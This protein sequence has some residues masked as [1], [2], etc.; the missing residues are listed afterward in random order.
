[1]NP[2]ELTM[3]VFTK[4]TTLAVATAFPVVTDALP[5]LPPARLFPVLALV[6]TSTEVVAVLLAEMDVA[7]DELAVL[8]LVCV[9][10]GS[11]EL[12]VLLVLLE[13]VLVAVVVAVC[14]GSGSDEE[15]VS[16]AVV[17]P[18]FGSEEVLDEPDV[19]VWLVL[20]WVVVSLC[21]DASSV[22]TLLVASVVVLVA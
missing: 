20:T 3:F 11:L 22:V 16:C 8:L 18:G 13:G 7:G 9:A 12:A 2:S 17:V 21:A 19:S 5:V 6:S 4:F 1:M 14:S 15:A 10:P